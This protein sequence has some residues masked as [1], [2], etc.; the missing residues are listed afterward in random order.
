MPKIIINLENKLIEEAKRQIREVGYGAVTIRSVAKGCGVGVGTVYNYFPSKDALI[1]TYL[2]E[3]WNSCIVSIQAVSTYSETPEPVLRCMHDQLKTFAAR[4]ASIFTDETAAAA[5]AGSF[6]QYH[7]MLRSQ[8][9]Q[10]L[11]KFCRDSFGAEFVAEALLAWTMAGKPFS[12]IY[13]IVQ[14]LF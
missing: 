5:F 8:L 14:K 4:H 1:A 2:L 6:S 9:A 10:P 12:E 13:E 3:D 7:T 11:G